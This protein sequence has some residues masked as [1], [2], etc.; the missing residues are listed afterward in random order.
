MTISDTLHGGIISP[1]GVKNLLGAEKGNP[2]VLSL[3]RDERHITK[4]SFVLGFDQVL[5]DPIQ[6]KIDFTKEVLSIRC[7]C[8]MTRGYLYSSTARG[9]GGARGRGGGGGAGGGAT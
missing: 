9:G 8:D 3:V 2:S 1:K 5:S 7:T 6:K 4:F